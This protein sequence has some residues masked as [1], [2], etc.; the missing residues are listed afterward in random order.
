MMSP[1]IVPEFL[2]VDDFWFLM[3]FNI[4]TPPIY[5]V[6]N[7]LM[8]YKENPLSVGTLDDLYLL[9]NGPQ[10]IIGI[11]WLDGLRECQRFGPL[12]LSVFVTLQE[13]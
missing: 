2:L 12:K 6:S 3:G 9:L 8:R 5:S 1:E 10:P 11:H 7:Q 4:G 13:L